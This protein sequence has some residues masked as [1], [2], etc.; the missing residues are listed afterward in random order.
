MFFLFSN[1]YLFRLIGRYLMGVINYAG[2]EM[3]WKKKYIHTR[4]NPDSAILRKMPQL[5]LNLVHGLQ[6][7]KL[8][9]VITRFPQWSKGVNFRT[10]NTAFYV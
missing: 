8:V 10:G 4:M 2:Q 1:S 7:R 3:I 5:H 6:M 9:V